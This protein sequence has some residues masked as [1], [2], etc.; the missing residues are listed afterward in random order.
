MRGVAAVLVVVAWKRSPWRWSD[1]NP[2]RTWLEGGSP[3][4][5]Q[6]PL[7]HCQGGCGIQFRIKEAS[8]KYG[9][10]LGCFVKIC[11]FLNLGVSVC[12]KCAARV[13]KFQEAMFPTILCLLLPELQS[14]KIYFATL[15]AACWKPNN[16][17]QL[18]EKK[19]C[20]RKG[21]LVCCCLQRKLS[22][23][24]PWLILQTCVIRIAIYLISLCKA[25]FGSI[26]IGY[27]YIP[28]LS[29]LE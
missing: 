14:V 27:S 6:S 20:W 29:H 19:P 21:N 8:R 24:T 4:L 2:W 15:T 23:N 22:P 11:G 16:N 26:V 18:L 9:F 13:M 10:N 25:M 3:T 1:S 12:Q 28:L 5:A 7:R 17:K